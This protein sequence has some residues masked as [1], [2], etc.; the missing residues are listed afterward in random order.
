MREMEFGW[1]VHYLIFCL[2]GDDDIV[3]K[4]EFSRA[5]RGDVKRKLT[6]LQHSTDQLG[7]EEVASAKEKRSEC[8]GG[9]PE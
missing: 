9:I 5:G 2:T 4:G 6:Y 3:W 7:T 8:W 1:V